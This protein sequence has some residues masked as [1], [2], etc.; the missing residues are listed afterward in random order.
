VTIITE[1]GFCPPLFLIA[2]STYT[3]ESPIKICA[4][5]ALSLRPTYELA[6][7]VWRAL[8]NS[9]PKASGLVHLCGWNVRDANFAL[10]NRLLH[11]RFIL[12]HD[13]Q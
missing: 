2:N 6:T 7:P 5:L 11:R 8:V 4:A 10:H 3:E 1:G 13:R 12:I 9:K